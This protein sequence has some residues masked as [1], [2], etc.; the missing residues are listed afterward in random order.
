MLNP[1]DSSFLE[2]AN[3]VGTRA[4]RRRGRSTTP[5]M[6][7]L[8]PGAQPAEFWHQRGAMAAIRFRIQPRGRNA[9]A[10]QQI[11]AATQA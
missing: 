5:A 3:G 7:R 9:A 10:S 11:A 4:T 6:A 8:R 2:L 1:A